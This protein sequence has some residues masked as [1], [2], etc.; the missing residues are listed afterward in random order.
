M[1]IPQVTAEIA[2]VVSQVLRN[3]PLLEAVGSGVVFTAS[4]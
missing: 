1:V 3:I 4:G 2:E